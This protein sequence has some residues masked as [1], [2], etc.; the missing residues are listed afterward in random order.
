VSV[1]RVARETITLGD[2]QCDQLALDLG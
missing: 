1:A 2:R